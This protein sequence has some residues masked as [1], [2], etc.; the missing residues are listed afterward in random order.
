MK[1]KIYPHSLVADEGLVEAQVVKLCYERPL[2]DSMVWIKS[3]VHVNALMRR[4]LGD[5]NLDL[6]EF[7]WVISLTISNR[8][9]AISHLSTGNM[10][11]TVVSAR[12]I[13]QTALLLNAKAIILIHS[14]PSGNLEPSQT[15]HALTKHLAR[16]MTLMDLN[17]LDH[18]I[19][20]SEGYYSTADDSSAYH[21]LKYKLPNA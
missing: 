20:T 18:V 12:D 16:A 19:L 17:F 7:A 5:Q 6:K 10:T 13:I 9:L 1:K 21:F 3:S 4:Y 2:H 8:V 14:H 15:D 11:S